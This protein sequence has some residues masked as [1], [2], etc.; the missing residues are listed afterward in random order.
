MTDL[1]QHTLIY[2]EYG[3]WNVMRGRQLLGGRTCLAEA[4]A[5]IYYFSRLHRADALDS[6][7]QPGADR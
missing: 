4:L 7:A 6:V 3:C 2:T 1:S 5:L